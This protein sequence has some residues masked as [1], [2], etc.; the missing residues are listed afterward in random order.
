M[1]KRY[2]IKDKKLFLI[3]N[4]IGLQIESD[5]IVPSLPCN[6][7]NMQKIEE[8][9]VV[10]S[11]DGREV[12]L[13]KNNM[14]YGESRM[15]Y[16]SGSIMSQCFYYNDML[17]GSSI[18]FCENKQVMSISW[19]YLGKRQGEMIQYYHGNK[20]YAKQL[21]LEDRLEGRQQF[22]YKNGKV[23]TLQEYESGKL[24][25]KSILYY[26]N[27][28]TKRDT[29]FKNGKRDGW[30]RIYYE[31][32]D[33]I[34]D[35]GKYDNGNPIGMHVR[36]NSRGNVIEEKQYHTAYRFD[37]FIWDSEGDLE[38]EGKYLD[39]E[40]YIKKERIGEEIIEKQGKW[41]GEKIVF[42]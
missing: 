37:H 40:N 20:V 8:A 28:E 7:E 39:D 15:F 10:I 25:G 29:S 38:M 36:R 41:D 30:D 17:H 11:S 2:E 33:V 14:K 5:F 4:R 23:K 16:P 19:F 21:F 32:G 9:V 12:F 18:F 6:Y 1:E 22:F 34:L 31:N 24:H 26:E 27:G 35:E 42:Q 3:D 13:E